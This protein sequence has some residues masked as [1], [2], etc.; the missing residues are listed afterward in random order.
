MFRMVSMTKAVKFQY[1]EKRQK[2]TT[3][4]LTQKGR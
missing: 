1:L 2:K 4:W 3:F